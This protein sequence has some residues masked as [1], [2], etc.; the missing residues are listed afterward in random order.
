MPLIPPSPPER[1]EKNLRER[2]EQQAEWQDNAE[3]GAAWTPRGGPEGPGCRRRGA[4]ER[5]CGLPGQPGSPAGCRTAPDALGAAAEQERVN[6]S[7]WVGLS[8]GR[9]GSRFSRGA[10]EG[11]GSA[12]RGG[13]RLSCR[14][15]RCLGEPGQGRHEVTEAFAVGKGMVSGNRLGSAPVAE[16]P[17]EGRSGKPPGNEKMFCA[18]SEAVTMHGDEQ[19]TGW[20]EPGWA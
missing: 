17:S 10:A 4:G 3:D 18:C 2:S 6:R 20:S 8:R 9:L 11:G 14:L 7:L 12:S 19:E 13:G 15:H 5:R 16:D 1:E